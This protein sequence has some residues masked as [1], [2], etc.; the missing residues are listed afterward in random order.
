MRPVRGMRRF[1]SV[2]SGSVQAKITL[3]YGGV[4]TIITLAVLSSV[5]WLQQR[6]VDAKLNDFVFTG[7]VSAIPC[8]PRRPDVACSTGPYQ[9]SKASPVDAAAGPSRS[10]FDG[11][12]ELH[13]DVASTQQIFALIAI[14]AMIV[15]AFAVCWWL[16]RRILRPLHRVTAT[17]Q[18]LSLSTLHERIGLTGPQDELKDLADTFDA[19]LDRLDRA[20][21]SQRRFVANASHEL[22]T[23]LAIQRTAIEVGLTKPSAERVSR[24]RDELLRATERSERLIE[25][26][27]VLA[28]GEQELLDRDPV[29]LAAVVTQVVGEHLPFA[30]RR[31]I[32]LTTSTQ[33]VV[34]AGDDT[35]LTRLVANL[36]Q[37][38]IRHNNAGGYVIID[39]SAAGGLVVCNSGPHVPE[40]K[41]DG[42]FEP[43]RR[44]PADRT[45]SSEGAG[46]GLSIVSAITHAHDGTV[47]ATANS[48]GGLWVTVTL[49]AHAPA[50]SA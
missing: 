48:E 49:P 34:V 13:K 23:P 42:L 45:T 17:A 35:L 9:P 43:F 32:T 27:L 28:Q 38:A 31:G 46:L 33:P 3:L 44:L 39:L 22:R 4:F 26:L 6:F 14:A 24:I 36:V 29:D 19:M 15:L 30:E 21:A 25:G 40:D 8:P 2:I 11:N 1:A 41:V 50:P 37:N 5:Q 7:P 47:R 16:T 20:V 12:E 10:I 18:R